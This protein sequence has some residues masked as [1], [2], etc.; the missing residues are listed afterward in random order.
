M[1]RPRR[2][3]LSDVAETTQGGAVAGLVACAI[4]SV[5]SCSSGDDDGGAD[6]TSSDD[7][8]G[9]VT[10]PSEPEE[11]TPSTASSSVQ[12]DDATEFWV[13]LANGERDATLGFVSSALPGSGAVSPFG[14][15]ETLEGPFDWYEAVGW[16]WALECV[17]G[18]TGAVECTASASDAW[19]DASGVEPVTGTFLVRFDDVGIATVDPQPQ[20][21][22]Q[23]STMVFEPIFAWVR[24]THPD[25]ADVMWGSEE[26][27]NAEILALFAA[28]HRTLCRRSAAG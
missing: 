11:A 2:G 8:D 15:T 9:E 23:W 14:R 13:A 28:K 4:L 1:D 27:V 7:T 17:S 12:V 19:S 5:T 16:K 3:W 26:D 20:C 10:T 18:D 21:G 6:A 24:T 25:D 22:A